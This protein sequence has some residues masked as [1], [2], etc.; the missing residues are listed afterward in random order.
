MKA[1]TLIELLWSG[2]YDNLS[3]K[4]FCEIVNK[5]TDEFWV[6]IVEAEKMN[7]L[8]EQER[9]TE[10]INRAHDIKEEQE[11]YADYSDQGVEDDI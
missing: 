3:V 9:E 7:K 11:R 2:D 10:E 8:L 1:E 5:E 4:E 6:K